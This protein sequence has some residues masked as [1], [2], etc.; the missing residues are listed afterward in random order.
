MQ[1]RIRYCERQPRKI[2]LTTC[3]AAA[4]AV[5]AQPS[6][7]TKEST[8]ADSHLAP[9]QHDLVVALCGILIFF[10]LLLVFLN[11]G[12][13]MLERRCTFFDTKTAQSTGSLS[14]AVASG[15]SAMASATRD[16]S[17][18][19]E[20]ARARD[21][22]LVSLLALQLATRAEEQREKLIN[23]LLTEAKP[24]D[25]VN[26]MHETLFVIL[27]W[28]VAAVLLTG[29]LYASLRAIK[30][31]F[32]THSLSDLAPTQGEAKDAGKGD[33][34]A[35][36][37]VDRVWL[38]VPLFPMVALGGA[39]GV[40]AYKSYAQPNGVDPQYVSAVSHLAST[41][42]DSELIL[43][44]RQS[45]TLNRVNGGIDSSQ[46]ALNAALIASLNGQRVDLSAL[47]TS[48]RQ[49][50]DGLT[51]SNDGAASAAAA[52]E[53]AAAHVAAAAASA[54][55]AAGKLEAEASNNAVAMEQLINW[56][57]ATTQN[58]SFLSK[59]VSY[60]DGETVKSG[61]ALKT[62]LI[63]KLPIILGGTKICKS[64]KIEKY[65]VAKGQDGQPEV[66]PLCSD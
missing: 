41:P 33:A 62:T 13:Q 16:K 19:G 58:L 66:T 35:F 45:M 32:G 22:V 59:E 25:A 29:F 15:P 9:R 5:S 38:L 65:Q 56:A 11:W 46:A 37:G 31:M 26:K 50:N 43:L 23:L 61:G 57:R 40:G 51:R 24:K 21:P 27:Y 53:R 17:G 47:E 28:A 55:V 1:R 30:L 12:Q 8:P 52:N 64:G 63:T 20:H 60:L 34:S 14:P 2:S 44:A 10:A 54:A 49:V 39:M 6:S 4:N 48:A 42:V 3:A 7:E 18:Q 36:S